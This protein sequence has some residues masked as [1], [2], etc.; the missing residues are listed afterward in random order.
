M[1]AKLRVRFARRLELEPGRVP[2]SAVAALP[3][4]RAER[5]ARARPEIVRAARRAAART[6]VPRARRLR[7]GGLLTMAGRKDKMLSV[8]TDGDV[9]AEHRKQLLAELCMDDSEVSAKVIAKLLQ[10]AA[11]GNSRANYEV[12]LDELKA[13]LQELERGP[14]RTATFL[15][16]H[17]ADGGAPRARVLLDDGSSASVPIPDRALVDLLQCGDTVFLEANGKAL[18]FR[19]PAPPETGEEATLEVVLDRARVEVMRR[20]DERA[21]YRAAA[22]LASRIE[23]GD[24][25]LGARLLVCPRQRMAF[26]ALPPADGYSH[27]RF[28]ARVPVPEVDA[29]RDLGAP[30]RYIAELLAIARQE[31]ENPALRRRWRLRRCV[32]RLLAGV[33]GSGKSFSILALWRGLYELMS[34]HT[35]TPVEALPP[36]VMRLRPA[37]VLS[38]WLGESDKNLA[39]FFDEV[40]QLADEEFVTDDGR[41]VRLPVLVILEEADGVARGRGEE[42]V[43]DRILTT[44]LQRLDATHASVS[45]RLILFVATTNVAHL[46]DPAFLR[47]VGGSVERFGRLTR[48]A[49]MLVLDKQLVG[50]PLACEP[51]ETEPEA[52]RRLVAEVSSWVH[53]P[54]H[55]RQPLIE[56]TFAG[57]TSRV[58]KSVADFL[59]AA[60]VDLAVQR[61][62]E[63]GCLREAADDASATLDRATLLGAIEEVARAT[64]DQLTETNA[65]QYLDLP[66]GAR[67][68][69]LHRPA[70][71]AVQPYEIER[72]A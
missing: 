66:D 52:R 11:A 23:A 20:G 35:G 57:S 61:A 39:R 68:A 49:F 50:R 19:D 58:A 62:A 12:K 32:T 70:P 43:H 5:A 44:M 42:P 60:H 55:T 6:W 54:A 37:E 10:A 53:G 3:H 24:V 21:V 7:P 72:V 36:R 47:R 13:E 22:M 56:L 14:L 63:A 28:L 69:S 48:R 40:E 1:H 29:A 65:H 67:V 16:L 18:L 30:P 38:K 46:V 9:P 4:L 2:P 26:D 25:A 15:A 45:D 8:L 17:Q 59:T 31:L 71:P 34:E 64:V 41:R 27:Y 33:S 51:G